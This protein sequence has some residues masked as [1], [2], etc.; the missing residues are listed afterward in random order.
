MDLDSKSSNSEYPILLWDGYTYWALSYI[1]NRYSF[2]IVTKTTNNVMESD[3]INT[4]S[5][6]VNFVG[7]TGEVATL[8]FDALSASPAD[9]SG[10]DSGQVLS[11]S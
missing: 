4:T 9:T 1:N 6:E 10:G 2:A 11:A 5:H 3:I 8:S 7:Q